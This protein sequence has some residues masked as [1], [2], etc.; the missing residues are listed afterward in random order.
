MPNVPP[1]DLPRTARGLQIQKIKILRRTGEAQEL[2]FG[3]AAVPL[4]AGD[5]LMLVGEKGKN[6]KKGVY[7]WLFA[8]EFVPGGDSAAAASP[9]EAPTQTAMTATPL[10]RVPTQAVA[11]VPVP[12]APVAPPAVGETHELNIALD[13]ASNVFGCVDIESTDTLADV[14]RRVDEEID[15]TSW[16]VVVAASFFMPLAVFAPACAARCFRKRELSNSAV[17]AVPA[18]RVAG[19]QRATVFATRLAQAVIPVNKRPRRWRCSSCPC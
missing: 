5:V 12:A 4:H 2:S 13:E 15:A 11:L 7:D 19:W 9:A 18:G 1:A 14:R 10:D 3:A 8:F 6:E 17:L 16:P